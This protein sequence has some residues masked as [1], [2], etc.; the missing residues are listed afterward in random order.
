MTNPNPF[1]RAVRGAVPVKLG[2]VGPSGSGKTY[3]ALRIARGIA[4]PDGRV[5]LIDTEHGSASLY[6]DQFRF[7]A[8]NMEPPYRPDRFPKGIEVATAAGYDVLIIDGIS[9]AWN[10]PGGVMEIVD[11]N[12]KGENTWSG[13]AKGSPAHQTLIQGILGARIHLICTMRSKQGWVLERNEKGKQVPVK[14]G[15][16]PVQR[17]GIDYEFTVIGEIDVEH[18]LRVT[19][20]RLRELAVGEVVP[21]PGEELGAALV[22]AVSAEESPVAVEPRV[23]VPTAAAPE[24][25]DE[26]AEEERAHAAQT[27]LDVADP[28]RKVITKAQV[29]R[30]ERIAAKAGI[31]TRSLLDIVQTKT[32]QPALDGIERRWYDLIVAEVELQGA[33]AQA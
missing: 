26:Q 3:T 19:K 30:L 17:D 27:T 24:T 14:V 25:G 16:E 18:Q 28:D 1:Q 6:A 20:S 11:Q 22:L 8:L 32:G 33:G 29:G 23:S 21:L 12:T 9:P 15:L 7:D 31:S 10:G 4:G 13:W 5:A 2:L